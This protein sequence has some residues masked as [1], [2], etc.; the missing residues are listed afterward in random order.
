MRSFV[1]RRHG[2]QWIRPRGARISARQNLVGAR[3][4]LCSIFRRKGHFFCCNSLGNTRAS[5]RR[6]AKGAE[7]SYLLKRVFDI[8]MAAIA[9]V[10][11]SPLIGIVAVTIY[12]T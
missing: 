9:L 5:N 10:V 4:S 1:G 11:L 2:T 8:L 6:P 3:P 7:L 12:F